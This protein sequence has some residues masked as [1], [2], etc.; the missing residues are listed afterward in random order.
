MTENMASLAVLFRLH[1][2]GFLRDR[3]GRLTVE[4][5]QTADKFGRWSE[6]VMQ[7]GIL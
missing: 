6:K 4:P 3:R 2:M 7:K 5:S 1:F